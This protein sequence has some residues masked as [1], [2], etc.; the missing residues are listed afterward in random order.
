MLK[1]DNFRIFCIDEADELISRG[2]KAQIQEIFK[3][4]PTEIQIAIFSASMP[5]EVL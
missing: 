2:F 3:S 1:T 5:I 4:L